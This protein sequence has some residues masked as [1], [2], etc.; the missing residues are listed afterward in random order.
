M[1]PLTE[2]ST[3]RRGK[4]VIISEILETAK[5]GTVKTRIMY[6]INLSFS[7]ASEYFELLLDTKLMD[8]ISENGKVIYKTTDKGI[9]FLQYYREIEEM[10]KTEDNNNCKNSV[11]MPPLE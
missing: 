11:R 2:K 8:K 7:Q 1:Y 10:I 3:K 5:K 9:E 6:T 4:H